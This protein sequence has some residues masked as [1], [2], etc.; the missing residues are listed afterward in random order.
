MESRYKDASKLGYASRRC[1]EARV[2][3]TGSR[4]PSMRRDLARS[5]Q[6]LFAVHCREAR[7]A[8]T[9]KRRSLDTLHGGMKKLGWAGQGAGGLRYA[10][11]SPALLKGS[12]PYTVGRL[13]EPL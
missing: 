13:G 1:K 10:V 9:K 12:L 4:Q 11:L 3:L 2:G 5:T 7:R 8:V 6:G